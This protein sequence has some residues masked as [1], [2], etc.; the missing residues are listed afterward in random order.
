[1]R[2]ISCNDVREA[3]RKVILKCGVE[4]NAPCLK[5]M[6]DAVKYESGAARFALEIM[7]K[8]ADIAKKTDS[9]LC[10]DT[11]MAVIFAEI[12]QEVAFT[13]GFIGDALNEGVRLAYADGYFRKSVLD[14]L[15]RVNTRD[16]T[17]AIIHYEIVPGDGFKAHVM[18][19]GFGS[20]NM[21]RL[22]M[23]SP[24]DGLSGVENAVVRSVLEAGGNPCPPVVVGVGI[25]G[26]M[27]KAALMSKHA[28]LR[29]IDAENPDPALAELEKKLTSKI[30][31]SGIG[32]QGFG[33]KLTCLGVLIEKYPTHLAGLPV[34][35]TMQ[36]HAVRHGSFTL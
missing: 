14:P 28:L 7:L 11:G 32:S 27:E 5:V 6:Q 4:L 31:E 2:T 3:L 8:N 16:N 22:F 23:L 30:N 10:Q 20:E 18:L 29:E 24:S 1:M 13:D 21:S 9:P 19:K 17:P 36:C 25:G 26:T 35:V 15:T 12:G 33:G 34:A